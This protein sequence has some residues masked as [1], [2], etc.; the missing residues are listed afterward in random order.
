MAFGNELPDA[1]FEIES[2]TL[3]ILGESG[4]ATFET[5]PVRNGTK[6][7]R[8]RGESSSLPAFKKIGD[9]ESPEI[10][11]STPGTSRTLGGWIFPDTSHA[12]L[13]LLVKHYPDGTG[14][15]SVEVGTVESTDLT[16]NQWNFVSWN[17]TPAAATDAVYIAAQIRG[18]FVDH[19]INWYFDDWFHG[20]AVVVKLAERGVGSI[21]ALLQSQLATELTAIDTDRADGVTM[22]APA[23][24]QYYNRPDPEIAGATAHVEVFEDEYEFTHALSDSGDGRAN[25]DLP[26]TIRV[27][28]FNR[29]G[30]T[31][32]TMTTR[33]RR[34]AAGVF[35]ALSKNHTLAD[36]DD[37]TIAVQV[38]RVTPPWVEGDDADPNKFKGRITLSA[39]VRCGEVQT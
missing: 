35:N 37:A 5:A 38:E 6:A 22:A 15:P 27:T 23:N 29:D 7:L 20:D 13:E 36:S 21:I 28:Y 31:R 33:G 1:G 32:A 2:W 11:V 8:L 16:V 25:Y 19:H 4:Y 9:A 34:Y 14:L 10:T 26:I 24:G 39:T 18:S 12:N 17:I 3:D 30:D